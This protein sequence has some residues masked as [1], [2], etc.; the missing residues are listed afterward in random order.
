MFEREFYLGQ[1]P[2]LGSH[3]S[4]VKYRF[5]SLSCCLF[6]LKQRGWDYSFESVP[7][8]RR[9]GRQAHM[10]T[11]THQWHLALAVGTALKAAYLPP[12]IPNPTQQLYGNLKAN[13]RTL[14][15]DEIIS[16]QHSAHTS[17]PA[18]TYPGDRL[19]LQR[20]SITFSQ[21]PQGN[22]VYCTE[23]N[24]VVFDFGY[25]ELVSV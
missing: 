6:L 21:G 7:R 14:S 2:P 1:I 3:N 11:Q 10:H 19:V 24:K 15:G 16:Y 22:P 8:C 13:L 12:Y 4:L 25:K 5:L 18:L 17:L 9:V 20:P 23:S